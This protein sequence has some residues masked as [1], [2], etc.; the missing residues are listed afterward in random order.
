[1]GR[2]EPVIIVTK[3]RN[4]SCGGRTCDL[5]TETAKGSRHELIYSFT[6]IPPLEVALLEIEAQTAVLNEFLVPDL[7]TFS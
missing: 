3:R 2:F 7:Y 4:S 1:M 6:N 5:P